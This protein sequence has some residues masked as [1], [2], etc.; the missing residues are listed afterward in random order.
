MEGC[1]EGDAAKQKVSAGEKAKY[2]IME[3]GRD[4]K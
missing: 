2:R 3:S 1:K 4:S